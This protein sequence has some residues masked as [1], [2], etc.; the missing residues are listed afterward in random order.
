[1]DWLRSGL[2]LGLES[3]DLTVLH[4][5]LRGIVVFIAALIMVR[6]GDRRF[7]AKMN[8]LDVIL[9]F[10]LASMLARAVNGSS[11]FL[12]T[13][14]GG[15]VL[16][17]LHKIF[18]ALTFHFHNFGSVVK[19]QEKLII[20][21]GK[22]CEATMR[23]HHISEKDLLEELRQEGNVSSPERV[24]RAWIERS[25]RIS[26]VPFEEKNSSNEKE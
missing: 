24:E 22:I 26:V 3:K 14:V 9:G 23:A 5:G 7:L 4:V 17:F 10:I 1:M 12:P 8:P 18:A 25:G 13:I 6:I 20:E 2:G 11:P 15:F 16:V 19:G 21:N